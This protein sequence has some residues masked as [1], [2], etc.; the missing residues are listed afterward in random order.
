MNL[1]E[2]AIKKRTFTMFSMWVFLLAGVMAYF[3]LGQLEDPEFTVKTAVVV[4]QYPGASPEEVEL[5]VTDRIEIALQEMPQVKELESFSRAGLSLVKVYIWP[6]YTAEY[7]P[8]I[9]DE[10]RKKIRDV[11]AELPPGS[12]TPVVSDDF[13]DVYG[14]FFALVGDGYTFAELKKHADALKKE[15]SLV[16]GVSRVELWGDQTEC[17]YVNVR[18]TQISQLGISPAEVQRILSTQNAVALSGGMDIDNQRFRIETTGEFSSPED[19]GDVILRGGLADRE[20]TDLIRIRDIAEIRRGYVEPPVKEMRYNGMRSIGMS[21]SNVGGANVVDIGR[22]I[23]VRL[24]ELHDLLPIGVEIE[25]ISWQ[26]DQVSQ[27]I[28]AFLISLLQAIAIV[29]VV[30]WVAMGLR[31]ALVVGLTGLVFV[32]IISFLIMNLV[33]I[34]LQRMSL[35][36]LVVA[37]GMMVDNAIVV[38]DG[39]LVRMQKGMDRTKAAIE[40]ASQPAIPLLGATVIAVLAFY[41]IAASTES[42]GEYCATLFS[43]VGISLMVSWV[44]AVTAA[45]IMCMDFL[46]AP[47]QIGSGGMYDSGMYRLFRKTLGL[48]IKLRWLVLLVLVGVLGVSLY[49]FRYV[50]KMFFPA[51]ARQQL[52]VDYWAPEGTRIQNVAEDIRILEDI[53]LEDDRVDSVSVY[54]GAGPPRF[55]LPVDPESPNQAY[56]QLIVNTNSVPAV[57]ELF[58]ELRSWSSEN[59]LDAEVVVRKYGLGPSETWPIE[60][61]F[62][63]PAIADPFVLRSLAQEAEAIIRDSPHSTIVNNDWRQ[64]VKKLVLD[65]DQRNSR[66]TGIVRTDIAQAT[67]R[68]YDGFPVGL[69][70]EGDTLLPIIA[71]LVED[72]RRSIAGNIDQ[73]QVRSE[74]HQQSVPLSQVTRSIEV[75]WEDPAIWRWDRR[76]AITVQAVPLD[77]ATVLRADIIDEIEA[78]ELPPG[79]SMMWDGEY[80]SSRDAQA[81]LIPGMVPAFI[82]MGL[83]IVGLFNAYRPP[84]I[85]LCVIPFALIGVTVGLLVTRQPFGFVALL[86]AMSLIGMMTKNA[87]VLL[88]EV[89]I[90][91]DKGLEPYDAVVE[92]AVSRLRPVMLAAGTTVLGVIPLLPD[93]FWVSLAVTIMFGLALGSVLTVIVIPVL[94]AC[95]Y[96][97]ES[98]PNA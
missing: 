38:A 53:L 49:G 44:L 80:R 82:V 17:I 60:V 23:D 68:A 48:A 42:A 59:V 9:W 47:K 10:L 63:G 86:G 16:P 50:N 26:S 76:R 98:P 67:Q 61:R 74:L 72:E 58:D 7:L 6:R 81:S 39:I 46:P 12:G 35:G 73:L 29:L 78:I 25:R 2:L 31:T 75:D 41:P 64:K 83:I 4:T 77:L 52:M 15:L 96:K 94:Y 88:D 45:P 27:S 92:A 57:A 84:L 19:I 40:A 20:A 93:V 51:S 28:S 85:I 89:N 95:F 70:R 97:L 65:F 37:M 90:N 14:F 54:I 87:I 3:G 18:Q 5:E 43:V 32:I 11:R 21:I 24:G 56:A 30:L 8:Q 13:G 34:D 66:W 1:A 62:S 33:G 55:Y 91:L 22:A 71:R 36:A 69:Y 79:Y